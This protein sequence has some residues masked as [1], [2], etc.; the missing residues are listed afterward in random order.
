[1]GFSIA[2]RMIARSMFVVA[3]NQ[4]ITEA[5]AGKA[6]KALRLDRQEVI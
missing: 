1:M 3:G 6:W 5:A 2:V 4:L